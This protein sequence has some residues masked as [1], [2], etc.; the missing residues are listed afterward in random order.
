MQ[1]CIFDRAAEI[2][3]VQGESSG[4]P[5]VDGEMLG[6]RLEVLEERMIT[7]RIVDIV[8]I[9]LPEQCWVT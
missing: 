5:L 4:A 6:E 9:H 8:D 1:K 2:K 3:A 7:Y